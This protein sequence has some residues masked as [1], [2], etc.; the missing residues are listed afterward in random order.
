LA[1]LKREIRAIPEGDESM[2]AIDSMD[3][4]D[5]IAA[6]A[7]L[8]VPRADMKSEGLRLRPHGLFHSA[9]AGPTTQAVRDEALLSLFQD[10]DVDESGTVTLSE[11]TA[12]LK[13]TGKRAAKGAAE[14]AKLGDL[15]RTQT[16]HGRPSICALLCNLLST[17]TN[18]Q[19]MFKQYVGHKDWRGAGRGRRRSGRG[20][21]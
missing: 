12:Y 11:L 7:K 3:M 19:A 15:T 9:M 5:Q 4:R 18:I 10:V 1:A 20:E 16:E 14:R 17:C 2:A 8:E 21:A 6:V 13:I